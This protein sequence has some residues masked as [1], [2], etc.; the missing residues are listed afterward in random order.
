MKTPFDPRHLRRQQLVEE[1]FKRDFHNQPISNEAKTIFEQREIID[2]EITTIAPDF[3]IH[4]INKADLAILRLAVYELQ[5]DKKE[6]PRVVID[7]AIELA[8]EYGNDTSPTFING[9][10]GR[11]IKHGNIT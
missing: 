5:I 4:K 8:K 11:M 1:L 6:P 3:P 2:K 7:E 10:L 9:A